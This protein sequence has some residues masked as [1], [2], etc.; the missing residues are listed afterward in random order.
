VT[1]LEVELTR[2]GRDGRLALAYRRDPALDVPQRARRL[3]PD[4]PARLLL[5]ALDAAASPSACVPTR[6]MSGRSPHV[7]DHSDAGMMGGIELTP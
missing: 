7:L 3:V 6:S 1:P 2:N 4:P 5:P